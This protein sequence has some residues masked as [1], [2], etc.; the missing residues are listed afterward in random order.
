MQ[1]NKKIRLVVDTNAWVS[2]MLSPGFRVRLKMVFNSK[3]RLLVSEALFEDLANAVRKPYLARQ[4]N[5][6]NYARLVALLKRSAELVD[7]RSVVDAC[8]DP[9]DNFLLALAKD[10]HADYLITG[11]LDLL[12]MQRFEKTKIVKLSE[13]AESV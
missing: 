11:D 6:E 1:T 7:V 8:R 2:S 10:G 4:I 12:T 3:Y 13:F 9:K 5:P